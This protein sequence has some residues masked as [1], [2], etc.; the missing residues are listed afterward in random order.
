MTKH[1][2]KL[3]F[4]LVI[5]ILSGSCT[6]H[7][8][9]YLQKDLSRSKTSNA[10]LFTDFSNTNTPNTAIKQEHTLTYFDT[11][12]GYKNKKPAKQ[13]FDD[14]DPL[15]S[16]KNTNKVLKEGR[17]KE[18]LRS[19]SQANKPGFAAAVDYPNGLDGI[20]FGITHNK[21][22]QALNKVP[23]FEQKIS[24]LYAP[25]NSAFV[26]KYQ[27]TFHSLFAHKFDLV[28]DGYLSAPAY[29]TNFYGIG[30]STSNND[31]VDFY[32]IRSRHAR[33]SAYLQFK[34]SDK[35][36]MGLG[37]GVEYVDVMKESRN[38]IINTLGYNFS[39][40][41]FLTLKSYIDLDFSDEKLN[42]KTGFRWLTNIDYYK[43]TN[44]KKYNT[45]SIASSFSTYITPNFFL[46]I[47]LALRLGTETQLGDYNFYQAS[48]LGNNDYNL[49]G[50]RNQRFSGRTAYFGNSELRI[51]VLKIDNYFVSANLGAVAFYDIGKVTSNVRESKEWHS[52]YGPGIWLSLFDNVLFTVGYGI[53][54]EDKVF[55]FKTGFRF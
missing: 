46:P 30:N 35:V 48:T 2:T 17:I 9:S 28:L 4:F 55:S 42:P 24:F 27:S 23:S 22:K 51:P 25:K 26:L 44:N 53:S 16:N 34:Y 18:Y 39:P 15:D 8:S 43:Q 12:I 41:K 20:F 36:K 40:D 50:F 7:K 33:A 5:G 21:R 52:G 54:K 10:I 47:T 3:L 45:V 1:H 38:N 14:K 13:F 11:N 37:P 6:T 49:R 31:K 19:S 32:R 29:N